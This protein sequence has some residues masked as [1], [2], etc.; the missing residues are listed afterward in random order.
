LRPLRSTASDPQ[1][2]F[3]DNEC[4]RV[5]A[6]V[7]AW[8]DE[9]ESVCSA[10]SAPQAKPAWHYQPS[11][12]VMTSLMA[13]PTARRLPHLNAPIG[14]TYALTEPAGATLRIRYLACYLAEDAASA[15]MQESV[16]ADEFQRALLA[17]Q[18]YARVAAGSQAGA[19]SGQPPSIFSP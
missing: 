11:G 6:V 4:D 3:I 7:L 12:I 10:A 16:G 8:C 1:R 2:W 13:K 9:A 18:C 17:D 5:V 14:G 19:R 15:L